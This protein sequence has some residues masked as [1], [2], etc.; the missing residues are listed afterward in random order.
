MSGINIHIVGV[1][2]MLA[3]PVA[4]ASLLVR[5]VSGLRRREV[6]GRPPVVPSPE[7]A[8]RLPAGLSWPRC[9]AGRGDTCLARGLHRTRP[10][11]RLAVGLLG[12]FA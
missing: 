6:P 9:P 11:G 7:H 3:G 2:I 12:V 5:S 10:K 4:L 8:G 1:I